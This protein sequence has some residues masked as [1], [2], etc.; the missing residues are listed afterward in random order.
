MWSTSEYLETERWKESSKM[1]LNP[2]LSS[3]IFCFYCHLNNYRCSHILNLASFIPAI[4]WIF[5]DKQMEKK[6][7]VQKYNFLTYDHPT[8]FLLPQSMNNN[9][10]SLILLV[11]S[12]VGHVSV[13]ISLWL[14]PTSLG[15][16]C[17]RT[18]TWW[19][20]CSTN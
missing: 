6:I 15:I 3:H 11:H 14:F 19:L 20:N 16:L 13:Q 9:R 18:T 12:V 17:L 5:S 10:C 7:Y 8:H 4:K 2:Q 1:K